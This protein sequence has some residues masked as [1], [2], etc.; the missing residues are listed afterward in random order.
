MTPIVVERLGKK[1]KASVIIVSP[2]VALIEA[3]IEKLKCKGPNAVH[4]GKDT[5][6]TDLGKCQYIVASPEMFLKVRGDALLSSEIQENVAAVFID[7]SH[8]IIK[9]YVRS[10]CN[11]IHRSSLFVVHQ[12][13]LSRRQ[14]LFNS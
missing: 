12:S 11:I 14:F 4:L 5:T 2:L 13:F 8:C 1:V 9:W 7:E 6:S 10:H 3:Q